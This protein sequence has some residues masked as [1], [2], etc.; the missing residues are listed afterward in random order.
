M[1]VERRAIKDL[2]VQEFSLPIPPAPAVDRALEQDI[3]VNWFEV[4]GRS[5]RDQRPRRQLT[6]VAVE[7][8]LANPKR[9]SE[10]EPRIA[11]LLSL[12]VR[13]GV[14][15]AHDSTVVRSVSANWGEVEKCRLVVRRAE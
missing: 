12:L 15:P 5:L 8:T 3:L 9:H 11:P 7:I 1:I 6:P 10:I 2:P 14:I 13:C 4:A